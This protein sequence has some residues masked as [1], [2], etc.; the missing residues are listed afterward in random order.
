ML[1]S[2]HLFH[3]PGIISSSKPEPVSYLVLLTLLCLFHPPGVIPFSSMASFSGPVWCWV[4]LASLWVFHPP[5]IISF[6]QDYVEYCLPF[7]TLPSTRNNL[8]L[9]YGAKIMLVVAGF[10]CTIP[11]IMIHFFLL[12]HAFIRIIGLLGVAGH[13]LTIP[14]NRNL[15]LL[16]DP[17]N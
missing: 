6:F 16:N 12:Q 3:P 1:N 14:S 10:T 5:G 4:L 15:C 8:L 7:L 2:L 17:L 9:V 11:S 13:L